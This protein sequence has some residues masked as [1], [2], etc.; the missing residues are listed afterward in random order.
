MSTCIYSTYQ[1]NSVAQHI[2]TAKLNFERRLTP[3]VIQ[4]YANVETTYKYVDLVTL[5]ELPPINNRTYTGVAFTNG[6][7]NANVFVNRDRLLKL[8]WKQTNKQTKGN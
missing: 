2:D 1:N 8:V 5:E 6:Y 7:K 4:G 3:K